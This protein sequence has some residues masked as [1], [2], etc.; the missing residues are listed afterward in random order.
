MNKP[1]DNFQRNKYSEK[2]RDPRWQ[3]LRLQ[4]FERDEW[5]CQLCFDS[6]STLAVH[7]KYYAPKAEPWDYPLE[8][9]VT[10]CEAC[11]SDETEA[12]PEA[13]QNL[14]FALRQKGFYAGEV[15]L[16]A[17]SF[18]QMSLLHGE[19]VVATAY[20]RALKSPEIQRELIEQY[21][22]YLKLEREKREAKATLSVEPEQPAV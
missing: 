13:E 4:I 17:D 11:H 9:L 5:C 6:E 8:A 16:F 1:N 21:F 18:Q 14:L 19:G 2:L 3:K 7:H 12:R 20:E 22:E 10:L 15:Q